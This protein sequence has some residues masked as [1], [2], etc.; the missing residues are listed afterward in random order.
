ME[1]SEIHAALA[2]DPEMYE[3]GAREAKAEASLEVPLEAGGRVGK[4][5][6]PA[7]PSV[8]KSEM[9]GGGVGAKVRVRG[10]RYDADDAKVSQRGVV[11]TCY[12]SL[13]WITALEAEMSHHF[14]WSTF[15]CC[16]QF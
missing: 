6:A 12:K 1:E 8:A 4:T 10:V 14:R 2:E 11:K 16:N 15:E 9:D 13:L 3:A 7:H 5:G